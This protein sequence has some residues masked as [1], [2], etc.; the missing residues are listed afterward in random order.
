LY[1]DGSSSEVINESTLAL[2]ILTNGFKMRTS[3]SSINASGETYI[4]AA[5]AETPFKYARAR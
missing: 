5:F 2:D 4:F 1:A 3:G